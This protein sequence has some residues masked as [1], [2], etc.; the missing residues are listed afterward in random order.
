VLLLPYLYFVWYVNR[1]TYNLFAYSKNSNSFD[2]G[3][4]FRGSSGLEI[5]KDL[6][7]Q[8]NCQHLLVNIY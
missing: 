1:K 5:R 4:A 8:L 6:A 3:F 2:V 7:E